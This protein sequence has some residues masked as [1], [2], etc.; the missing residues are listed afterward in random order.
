MKL[1]IT[2]AASPFAQLLGR[3][4]AATHQ[5]R[6]T[7]RI[8]LDW[9]ATADPGVEFVCSSLGHDHGTNLLVRD[10]D[11]VI[12]VA[13]PLATDNAYSK[14]DILT[15]CT[16]NLLT[17]AVQEAVPQV[18]LL[19]TLALLTDYAPSYRVSERWRPHPNTDPTVLSKHLA[20]YTA[21][22]FAREQ[23]INVTILRL[24]QL[25]YPDADASPADA[26]PR[27]AAEVAARAVENVLA[28]P[29][30]RWAIYHI[31]NEATHPHFT[32]SKA[33]GKA[34]V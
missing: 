21:R 14:I 19:S 34:L 27:V 22:E 7:E 13:E 12:H 10:V 29:A 23:K 1:L 8:P 17:A 20:E 9:P 26:L 11:V 4:L 6:L 28:A 16:Y 30:E 25:V 33:K 5:I 18:L 32:M 31:G 2:A 3:Q 24:G 15:R